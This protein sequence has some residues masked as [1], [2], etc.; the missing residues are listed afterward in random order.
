MTRSK[1]FLL[2]NALLYVLLAVLAAAAAI[3]LYRE[4]KCVDVAMLCGFQRFLS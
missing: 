2:L 4:G 3:G 1:L